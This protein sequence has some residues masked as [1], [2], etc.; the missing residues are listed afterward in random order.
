MVLRLFLLTCSAL[1]GHS[2][3]DGA[4]GG[5]VIKAS[6]RTPAAGAEVVLRIKVEGQLAPLGQTT[7]DAQGKF[8]FES[9]P[10]GAACWYVPGANRDGI[11]YPGSPVRLTP[12][13]PRAEIA[14]TVSDSVA[15][16][17]PLVIQRHDITI[18]VEPGALTVR[19]SMLIDNPSDA[20]YVGRASAQGA[21]PVT[22]QLAIPSNFERC[23]FDSEFYGRRFYQ[24]DGKL[25]T[26]I[27]WTP[28]QR[29]LDFTYVLP[30]AQR[31]YV[32]QRTLDLP[33]SQVAV[34]VRTDRPEDVA[35]DLNAE[36]VR[37]DGEVVFQGA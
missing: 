27:P 21:E 33:C 5:V 3:G 16:P 12:Q 8:L 25:V 20:C 6:D 37:R 13:H 1:A 9:L 29:K 10:V 19:E 36:P 17:N 30:N 24:A 11:H 31:R 34:H 14:L 22:L 18:R 28:G 2:A 4:I 15:Y 23:T 35:C 26:S 32:W 7:A